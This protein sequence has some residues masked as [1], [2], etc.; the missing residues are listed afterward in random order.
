MNI[1]YEKPRCDENVNLSSL[2]EPPKISLKLIFF[3]HYSY[4][5][6]ISVLIANLLELGIRN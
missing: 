6:M 3:I 1:A 2:V 4:K 5:V